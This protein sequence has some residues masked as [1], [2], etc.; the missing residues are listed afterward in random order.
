MKRASAIRLRLTDD[1]VKAVQPPTDRR[2]Q[3][4]WDTEVKRFGVRVMASGERTFVLAYRAKN[5]GRWKQR[6]YTIGKYDDPWRTA[7]AREEAKDRKADVRR[8]GD[9]FAE[10]QATRD[11]PTMTTLWDRYQRH[12]KKQRP[13]TQTG[14]EALW[15]NHIEPAL[16]RKAVSEVSFDHCDRLHS[17]IAGPIAGNRA[18]VIL[19]GMFALAI[20]LGWRTDNPVVGVERNEETERQRYLSDKEMTR[21]AAALA[22]YRDQEAADAIR[23]LLLTG[24]RKNELLSATWP[25]FDL[26]AA[27]WSKP[28]SA[29]KGRRP[30][31][32]PLSPMALDLLKAMRAKARGVYLFPSPVKEGPRP[33]IKHNWRQIREAAGIPDVRPHDLRHSFASLLVSSG[34]TLHMVGTLLGHSEA[35]MARRYSHLA[36]EP[37]RNAVAKVGAAF[38]EAAS[39][40]PAEVVS[41]PKKA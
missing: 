39:K 8:G 16:G 13:G 20:K 29:M 17:R 15:R 38:S 36:I 33:D 10:N 7:A 41:F 19:S 21:L 9:P 6:L 22:A 28:A 2:Y 23:L 30:H 34:E 31:T 11:A 4:V 40:K 18:L 27:V 37:Q 25:Q 3:I 12:V 1:V 32:V 24:A 35:E 5:N 26:E 14:Y